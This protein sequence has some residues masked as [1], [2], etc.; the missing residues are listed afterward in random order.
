VPVRDYKLQSAVSPC[1]GFPI[2]AGIC[3]KVTI[4][5]IARKAN[6]SHQ[7]VSMVFAG[8][9]R[10]S[11]KTRERVLQVAREMQYIPNLAAR[12]LRKGKSNWIGLIVNDISNPFY[13]TMAKI[14]EEA[15]LEKGYQLIIADTQW[16]AARETCAIE[17][18]LSFQ[19]RGVLLCSTEQNDVD[20][21]SQVGSP[22]VVAVDT[23][24]P[25]YGGCFV[26]N[27]VAA[28]GR[29]AATHL[30]EIGARN[31]LLFTAKKPFDS[32]SS[33]TALK[34]GFLQVLKKNRLAA[35]KDRVVHSGLTIEDGREAFLQRAD[36]LR[37]VDAIFCANDMCAVGVMAGASEVGRKV[38]KDLAVMGI[39]DLPFSRVPQISLTTLRQPHE[40]IARMAVQVLIERIEQKVTGLVRQ[41]FLPELVIRQSSRL[42]V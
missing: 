32:F 31:P 6:V 15:A 12:N 20:L 3:M 29:L 9:P 4:K 34:K 36:S 8:E 41:V 7:A 22:V 13:G 27:D 33:F 18:M 35:G 11:Q 1:T 2:T 16:N 14:A 17:R 10:I 39:D 5:D 30:L 26:G 28:A 38:G 25:D 37:D 42:Q 19:V 21:L 23:C 40:E 24:A